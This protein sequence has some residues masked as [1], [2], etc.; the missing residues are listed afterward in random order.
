VEKI[1]KTVQFVS[2]ARQELKKVVWPARQQAISSTWVVIV[3]VFL[4]AIFLGLVDFALS[5][6][7]RYVLS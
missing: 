4:I 2:E 3:V 7:V 6:I 5:R 1:N